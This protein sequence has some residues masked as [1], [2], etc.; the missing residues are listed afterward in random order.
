MKNSTS[1]KSNIQLTTAYAAYEIIGSEF[2]KCRFTN[3]HEECK[4]RINFF[5]EKENTQ[6]SIEEKV[7]AAFQKLNID[8]SKLC[9][10]VQGRINPATG[11]YVLLFSTPDQNFV[12]AID[13][14]GRFEIF[15]L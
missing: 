10:Y 7:E 9:C 3:K 14:K 6:F 5:L 15:P 2:K 12:C 11:H 1:L 4:L 8:V 13:E